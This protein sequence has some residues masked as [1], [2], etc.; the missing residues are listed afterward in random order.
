MGAVLQKLTNLEPEKSKNLNWETLVSLL[1]WLSN[2][3]ALQVT[4]T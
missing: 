1:T 3:K 4:Q 2:G